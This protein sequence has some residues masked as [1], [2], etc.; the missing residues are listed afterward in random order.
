VVPTCIHGRDHA[1]GDVGCGNRLDPSGG[2]PSGGLLFNMLGARLYAAFSASP[3][4]SLYR[5]V[6]LG[7]RPTVGR[8]K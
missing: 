7:D 2:T 5:H 1:A 8:K 6:M 3:T 4:S